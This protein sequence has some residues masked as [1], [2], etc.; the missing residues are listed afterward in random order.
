MGRVVF[1]G[2]DEAGGVFVQ[3]MHDARAELAVDARKPLRVEQEG[4]HQRARLVARR[5]VGHQ[6][7]L[8]VHHQNISVLVDDVKG[9]V[10]GLCL[11]FAYF[12]K[13]HQ[14]FAS[15]FQLGARPGG[16]P[17]H[18]HLPRFDQ[19]FKEAPASSGESLRQIFIQPDC[20]LLGHKT[21]FH[22]FFISCP[23]PNLSTPSSWASFLDSMN[24]RER[25]RS[26]VPV[27]MNMSATLNTANTV[28]STLMKS[29]T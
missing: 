1:G 4:V 21:L 3:P 10:L 24:R 23:L 13:A 19:F 28:K 5:R 11:D 8:L 20:A 25:M 16:R 9:N 22:H 2:H 27:V 17:V 26:T 6:A 12:W 18:Q 7:F 15:R 29:T 14:H